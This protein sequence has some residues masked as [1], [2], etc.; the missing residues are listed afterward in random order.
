MLITSVI[1]IVVHLR[2]EKGWDNIG[3]SPW[4]KSAN[5]WLS[6]CRK[7]GFGQYWIDHFFPQLLCERDFKNGLLIMLGF[8]FGYFFSSG[9]RFAF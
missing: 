3:E 1:M 6:A 2:Q 8:N 4:I 5:A 7:K 9:I